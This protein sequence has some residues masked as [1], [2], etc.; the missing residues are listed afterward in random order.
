MASPSGSG[1]ST[2]SLGA[3]SFLIAT[4]S[5]QHKGD[6]FHPSLLSIAACSGDRTFVDPSATFLLAG[7]ERSGIV[8]PA[9]LGRTQGLNRERRIGGAPARYVVCRYSTRLV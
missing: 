8:G 2:M 3:G 1:E 6:P 9:R 7:V 4:C 5:H